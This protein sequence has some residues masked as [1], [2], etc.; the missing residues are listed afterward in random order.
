MWNHPSAIVFP[1]RSILQWRVH[2]QDTTVRATPG[3]LSFPASTVELRVLEKRY[4]ILGHLLGAWF[5]GIGRKDCRYHNQCRTIFFTESG[6]KTV[7]PGI[8]RP[9]KPPS[10]L[11]WQSHKG[12]TQ[13]SRT[14]P[15]AGKTFPRKNYTP[16]NK[17][18][19][20]GLIFYPIL[21]RLF[22]WFLLTDK[23][24]SMGYFNYLPV[25]DS[26]ASRVYTYLKPDIFSFWNCAV[27][28]ARDG[29]LRHSTACA[30]C[31]GGLRL[32]MMEVN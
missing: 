18:H 2:L 6:A 12:L 20:L 24:L 3:L 13:E 32:F 27:K 16:A 11:H 9:T 1:P 8:P 29:Q 22:G 31:V 30:K 21:I 5:T 10:Q 17:N 4:L 23:T 15:S 14:E 25:M 7:K 28:H 19:R 26:I